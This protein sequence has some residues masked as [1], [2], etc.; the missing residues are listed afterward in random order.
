MAAA[1][2]S[3]GKGKDKGAKGGKGKA[4]GAKKGTRTAAQRSAAAK[5]G[6]KTRAQ[7]AKFKGKKG[8]KTDAVKVHLVEVPKTAGVSVWQLQDALRKDKYFARAVSATSVATTAPITK[9]PASKG[10]KK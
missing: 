8:K 7:N 6:A 4:K 1:K 2:G 9:I 3:K 10:K 5:K